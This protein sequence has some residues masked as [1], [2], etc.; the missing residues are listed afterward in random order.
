MAS[1]REAARAD[2]R[3]PAAPTVRVATLDDLETVVRLRLA[4][5]R[6]HRDNAIYGRLRA[7]AAERARS[8]YTGQLTA[9]GESIFLAEHGREAVGILR[10]V[11][12][13]SSPLLHP[14]RYCYVSSVY[15]VPA[16]RRGGVLRALLA[17][18]EDWC[19]ARGLAEVRLHNAADNP[20]AN[21]TWEALGFRTVEVLRLRR[22]EED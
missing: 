12:S 17:A 4:L 20:V 2:A 9:A 19:R 16:A 21:A 7:D 18:A 1:A 13:S 6:E 22:L 3:R 10:C 5:L 8:L 11:E 15:V 14:A